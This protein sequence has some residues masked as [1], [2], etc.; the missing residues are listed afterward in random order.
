MSRYFIKTLLIAIICISVLIAASSF[1]SAEASHKPEAKNGMLDLNDWNW[2]EDGIVSLDG[3]WEFYWRE[4][5][6][7]EDFH[8]G[9]VAVEKNLI[10]VPKTWNNYLIEDE[11]LTGKGFA[12]YR[13]SVNTSSDQGLGIKIPKIFIAYKLWV[14]G[15]LE[16]SYETEAIN[17]KKN[18]SLNYPRV[19]FI[20][21]DTNTLEFVIQV[22]NER[23]RSG[24]IAESLKL[25]TDKQ[26]NNLITRNIAFDLFLFGCLFIIGIYHLTF[27]IY[28]QKDKSYIYF[29][30][31][32]LL[33][34]IRTLFVGEV[35]F[36]YLFPGFDWEIAHKIQTL[37]YYLGVP[38]FFLMLKS[39]FPDDVSKKISTYIQVFGFG[40]SLIVLLTPTTIF[41]YL[42]PIYQVFT[43]AVITYIIS[44]LTSVCYKKRE[45][46][47]IITIGAVI[48]M[49]ST[50]N[51]IIFLSVV[52]MDS[53]NLFLKN[54]FTKGN[55]SSWGLLIFIFAQSLVLAKNFSKSFTKVELITEQLHH[56]NENLEEKVNE[57]THALE[58]SKIELEKAY[59]AVHRSE[60]SRQN[61]VQNISHDLRTSLT[62]IKGYVSAIL[63]EIVKEPKQQKKYLG[64]VIDKVTSLDY[65]VQDL[66]ELSQLESR[67]I[68]L[69]LAPVSINCL[70]NNIVDNH[71]F[72]ANS[73]KVILKIHYPPGWK[74]N[75]GSEENLRL[76]V[77]TEQLNRVFTN[78]L[79][80]AL[81]YTPEDSQI[82]LSFHLIDELN[83]KVPAASHAWSTR[84]KLL[85]VIS[86]LGTGIAE[87]DLP[88]LFERFY[89]AEKSRQTDRHKSTGLGLAITKEIIEYHGGKIWVDSVVGEGSDFFFTLP[90]LD[91]S[92]N[93]NSKTLRTV[94]LDFPVLLTN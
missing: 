25:G 13:L 1:I 27:F 63:D 93:G 48:L 32:S 72:D 82:E 45:G 22:A 6:T 5:L 8:K 3:E 7:P 10:T 90:V 88:F 23:H 49:L 58:T 57:R 76:L 18:T 70:I 59:Q 78:L 21:P 12:T 14:N 43:L 67:H 2:S 36:L 30:I 86:D 33:V 87:E 94:G 24:G 83:E 89:K 41:T 56:L 52:M 81:R 19:I 40:I 55:L 16:A 28:R 35:F 60:K 17:N 34:S 74:T 75:N 68:K 46:S 79:S 29:G 47:Y 92:W 69:D 11:K 50:I 38:L 4:L 20:K 73:T 64:R 77:D 84:K 9:N 15:E 71:S 54:F 61:L 44:I 80:N 37:C 65:M 91:E 42:N 51:D 39:L 85:I 66:M 31:F 53:E 26:I 62:S